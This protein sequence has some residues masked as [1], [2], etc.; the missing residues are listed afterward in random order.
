MLALSSKQYFLPIRVEECGNISWYLDDRRG[1]T[2]VIATQ[3]TYTVFDE[4]DKLGFIYDGVHVRPT[5][6][7]LRRYGANVLQ[8]AISRLSSNVE[9]KLEYDDLFRRNA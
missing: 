3:F 6:R 1:G 7:T 5:Y 8:F 2:T 4:G 9:E